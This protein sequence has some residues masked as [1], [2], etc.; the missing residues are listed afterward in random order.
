MRRSLYEI[1]EIKQERNS[2]SLMNPPSNKTKRKNK[3]PNILIT[4][5]KN[6][7]AVIFEK[8]PTFQNIWVLVFSFCFI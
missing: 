7:Y 1:G 8:S 6:F 2:A 3:N 5:K 4:W